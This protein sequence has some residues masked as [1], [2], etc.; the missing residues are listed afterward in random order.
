MV[1]LGAGSLTGLARGS[2]AFGVDFTVLDP[3]EL[4]EE[5]R[6][7]AERHAALGGAVHATRERVANV[8]P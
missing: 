4:R 5:C 2:S 1:A 7:V 6:R 3:P 8:T